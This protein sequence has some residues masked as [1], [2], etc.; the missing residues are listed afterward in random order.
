MFPGKRIRRR[1]VTQEFSRMIGPFLDCNKCYVLLTDKG[2]KKNDFNDK[3]EREV[4]YIMY[5]AFVVKWN[6]R[7]DG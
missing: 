5:I 1:P 3:K 4:K 6:E 7:G 2:G